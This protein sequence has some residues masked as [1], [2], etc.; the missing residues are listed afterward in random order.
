[1]T[2]QTP[3]PS[4]AAESQQEP[5]KLDVPVYDYVEKGAD[6]EGFET[7]DDNTGDNE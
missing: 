5:L 1:M 3:E 6:P 4:S 2:E 7:R